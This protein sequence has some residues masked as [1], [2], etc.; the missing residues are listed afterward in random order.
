MGPFN[1]WFF[2]CIKTEEKRQGKKI[3]KMSSP[4]PLSMFIVGIIVFILYL[5]GYVYMIYKAHKQQKEEFEKDPEL[6]DYYKSIN[7]K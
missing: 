4:A 6:R 5:T 2:N 3:I 7:K 1:S